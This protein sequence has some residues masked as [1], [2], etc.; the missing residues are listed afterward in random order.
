MTDERIQEL[1]LQAMNFERD[2]SQPGLY[3]DNAIR[4]ALAERDREVVEWAEAKSD[5]AMFLDEHAF[6][7][8]VKQDDLLHFLEA[9]T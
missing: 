8:S 6:C 7:W 3:I 9:G 5:A 4:L 1:A 2:G